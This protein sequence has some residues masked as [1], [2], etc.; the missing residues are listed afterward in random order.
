[1]ADMTTIRA[2][3]M[4]VGAWGL[5]LALSVLWGGSFFF[6]KIALTDL[7]P[8][9]LVL[10]RV[11][12]AA[13][14]LGTVL[15][16]RGDSFPRDAALWRAFFG[17]GLLNNIIP[18]SLIFW[19]Q[20]EVASG[21]AAILN[22]TTPLFTVLV[23][24]WLTVDEPATPPKLTGVALGFAGV[25]VMIGPGLIGGL[26]A[27]PLAEAACLAA[28]LSY[29][30]AGVY[31]RCFKRLG[32]APLTTAFGTLTASTLL[33]LPIAA[34][35]DRFWAL[36]M[37]TV[38]SVAALICLALL[39]TALAYLI[40][41]QL[42]ASVGATNLLLVTFLIP[43]SAILLGAVFLGERLALPHFLG[44]ALIGSGLVAIDGR[45]ANRLQRAGRSRSL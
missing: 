18:F 34:L 44:M 5:L 37:P 29:A 19:G 42:L 2:R 39:S 28:A 3:S 13:L 10:G 32:A 27:S 31:G 11:A 23:A 4:S 41:Y 20:T 25:V 35:S 12:L 26:A 36:P 45:L 21:L 17:M 38:Q 15:A 30:F 7:P 14:A 1:M 40:F 16:W 6:S 9:T 24:H 8:F 33:M 43:V 22:A